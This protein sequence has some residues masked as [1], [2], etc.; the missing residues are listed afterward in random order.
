MSHE[1]R[2]P[3]NAIIGYGELLIEDAEDDGNQSL[4]ED[5]NKI[6]EAGR[7]LLTLINDILDLSKID[8]GKMELHLERFNIQ[9]LVESVV[10]TVDPLVKK[11]GNTLAL[12]SNGFSQ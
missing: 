9:Q 10:D 3:L 8:A 6:I 2:T 12:Q 5:L 1:L 4:I 7:H 11:N